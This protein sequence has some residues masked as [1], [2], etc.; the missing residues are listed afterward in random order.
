MPVYMSQTTNIF[1]NLINKYLSS[2]HPWVAKN[3]E[4]GDI[5]KLVTEVLWSLRRCLIYLVSK[6]Q[7]ITSAGKPGKLA[8]ALTIYLPFLEILIPKLMKFYTWNFAI[9]SSQKSLSSRK[10]MSYY[11][12]GS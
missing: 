2:R 10:D 7:T 4:S 9:M 6:S 12:G 5:A 8:W 11:N 3:C 1:L